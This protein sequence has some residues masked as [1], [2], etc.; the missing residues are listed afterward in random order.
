MPEPPS[1]DATA[2]MAFAHTRPRRETAPLPPPWRAGERA[3]VLSRLLAVTADDLGA[4]GVRARRHMLERLIE[5]RDREAR[6]ARA[7]HW[8]ASPLRLRALAEAILAETA[9]LEGGSDDLA[10]AGAACPGSA[11]NRARE[12]GR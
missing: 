9:A 10:G 3:R 2:A 6:R 7:G 1:P 8:S 4:D 11:E 12:T 5:A